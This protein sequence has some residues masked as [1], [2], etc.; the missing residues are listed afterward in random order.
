M[1]PTL[2]EKITKTRL[3]KLFSP[4]LPH[5]TKGKQVETGGKRGKQ[6]EKEETAGNSKKGKT[7][8]KREERLKKF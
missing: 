7:E 1:L 8:L 6:V 4:R 2:I 3:K 5:G